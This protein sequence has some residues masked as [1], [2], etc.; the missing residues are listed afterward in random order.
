MQLLCQRPYR[1][2][3]LAATLQTEFPQATDIYQ[4]ISRSIKRW[5]NRG[6]EIESSNR[7]PY[8]LRKTNLPLLLSEEQKQALAL[9]SKLL[10]NL[11]FVAE[12][13]HLGE[14]LLHSSKPLTV[15]CF[16]SNFD[17]PLP[18]SDTSLREKIA[19]LRDRLAN[20]RRFVILYRNSKGQEQ[21]W[22][23]DLAQL[24]LHDG[25]LFL[26]AHVPTTP[27]NCDWQDP[28][29]RNFSF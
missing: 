26:F 2:Q 24:H 28:T 7:T 8:I 27:V 12:G 14:I 18:Y 11:G 20:R 25:I 15:P 13:A 1:R 16:S 9:G 10:E 19:T 6:C 21:I 29:A 5:R 23:V 22:E 17:P 3:E 4:K